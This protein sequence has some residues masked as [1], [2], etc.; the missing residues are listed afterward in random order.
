MNQALELWSNL[1]LSC[2]G[3]LKRF[4]RIQRYSEWI[5]GVPNI[6]CRAFVEDMACCPHEPQRQPFFKDV[7]SSLWNVNQPVDMT[8]VWKSRS[9]HI[10]YEIY[11]G[12]RTMIEWM[13]FR[14]P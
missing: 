1:T 7:A 12:G 5:M 14:R 13:P 11:P 8:A 10:F 4:P 6:D 2:I 3:W 9:G